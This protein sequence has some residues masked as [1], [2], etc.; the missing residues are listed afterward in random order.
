MSYFLRVSTLVSVQNLFRAPIDIVRL[1]TRENNKHRRHNIQKVFI[2]QKKRTGGIYEELNMTGHLDYL[3]RAIGIT[4]LVQS[5]LS[6]VPT[7]CIRY[8]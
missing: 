8:F 5:T 3:T 4:F 2:I 1:P 7:G 6:E